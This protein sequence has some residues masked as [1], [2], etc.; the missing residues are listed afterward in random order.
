MERHPCERSPSQQLEP[1]KCADPSGSTPG[2]V[3]WICPERTP[4]GEG[5]QM[6][7]SGAG[8]YVVRDATL[9]FS[10]GGSP[11]FVR[12]PRSRF[13][14]L[15]FLVRVPR[16]LFLVP[17]SPF[18]VLCSAYRQGVGVPNC[19]RG[20]AAPSAERTGPSN[21]EPGTPNPGTRNEEPGEPRTQE[22]R[23]SNSE[24]EPRTENQHL[25]TTCLATAG[26]IPPPTP[27]RAAA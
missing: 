14:V 15:G 24:P 18:R 2:G 27:V 10:V 7:G 9:S 1:T 22:P 16:S 12:V 19:G 3:R 21:V 17:R 5:C 26:P 11:F 8:R 20:A 23:T 6:G 13:S 25:R 4:G